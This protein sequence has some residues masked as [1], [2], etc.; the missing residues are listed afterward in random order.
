M[1][2]EAIGWRTLLSAQRSHPFRPSARNSPAAPLRCPRL[3]R[4][5]GR[6]ALTRLAQTHA[7]LGHHRRAA[8]YAQEAGEVGPTFS[9]HLPS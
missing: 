2:R 5:A 6:E 3:A 9:C 8:A 7:G 1:W 4:A